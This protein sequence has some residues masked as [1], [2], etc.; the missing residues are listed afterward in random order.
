MRLIS[1]TIAPLTRRSFLASAGAAALA[2]KAHALAS[3]G[4]RDSRFA[5]TASPGELRVYGTQTIPWALVQAL[6]SEAPISLIADSNKRILHVLHDIAEYDGLPRGYIES[7]R[8]DQST[9]R[10]TS[11]TRR[12]LSLSAI[13]P[14]C[15]ALSP[16]GKTLAVAI[17]GGSAYNLLPIHDDGCPGRPIAIRKETGINTT[18]L[19]HPAQVN[20]SQDSRRI[21]ALDPGTVSISVFAVESTLPLLHRHSLPAESNPSHF[22]FHAASN[23][24]FVTSDTATSLITLWHNPATGC[25]TFI[26]ESGDDKFRGPLVIHSASQT[27][28]T[29][30]ADS[31]KTFYIDPQSAKL[32]HTQ[33]LTLP[34]SAHAIQS[35]AFPP[36][37]D[38]LYAATDY[39]IW[40]TS[41]DSQQATLASPSL[42]ASSANLIAWL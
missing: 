1:P 6:P 40:R 14:R 24:L 2:A 22:A 36:E 11:P 41:I 39:G 34:Q 29:A 4:I 32:Q 15:M 30:S 7:F 3:V 38:A 10:L 23:L 37:N 12:P 33:T 16:D 27:L 9:G 42:V 8:I 20:F 31:L 35:L 28:I 5:Y 18:S 19:S 25:L 21:L 13:H 17:H 26:S